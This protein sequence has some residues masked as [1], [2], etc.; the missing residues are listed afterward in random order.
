MVISKIHCYFSQ[1][2]RTETTAQ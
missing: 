1:S 2:P